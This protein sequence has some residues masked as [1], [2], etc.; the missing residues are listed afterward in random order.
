MLIRYLNL[1]RRPERNEAFL[2]AN[3]GIADFE[4]VAA[5]DGQ[6]L[7]M[8]ALVETGIAAESL[9]YFSAG[10]MGAALS[11]KHAWE[12]CVAE[13]TVMTLAED[14]AFFNRRFA[15]TA[16]KLLAS[17]PADWD[18]VFWGWNFDS[19]LHVEVPEG[20]NE[21][22]MYFQ[23]HALGPQTAAFQNATFDPRPFRLINLFGLACY[24]ISPAGAARLLARCFPLKN[25]PVPITGLKAN[26]V[27]LGIDTAMNA[28]YRSLRAYVSFPPL[29][30]TEND[31]VQSDT[32]HVSTGDPRPT[33]DSNAIGQQDSPN[34]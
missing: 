34:D 31:R 32:V 29:V 15:E 17:L 21:A 28:H 13:G 11:H 3:A 26:I 4:R 5:V 14:D 24:S 23:R 2:R 10:A 1:D 33:E 27:N 25:E 19:V 16:P 20:L 18:I 9:E 22:C 30:W 7:A 6:G 8:S 12:R